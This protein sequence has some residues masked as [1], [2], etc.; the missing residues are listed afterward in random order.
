VPSA[1]TRG[2]AYTSSRPRNSDRKTR[3][4]SSGPRLASVESA[5]GVEPWAA[6]LTVATGAETGRER[7]AS[8]GRRGD[9]GARGG[10]SVVKAGSTGR[11]GSQVEATADSNSSETCGGSGDRGRAVAAGSGMGVTGSDATGSLQASSATSTW[12]QVASASTTL[13]SLAFSSRR[14][15]T[16]A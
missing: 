4:S 13:L 14:R 6:D 3:T 8:I 9:S 10:G 16:P 5:G 11:S 12:V 2:M 1:A 7:G 15:T